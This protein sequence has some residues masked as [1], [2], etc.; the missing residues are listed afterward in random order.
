MEIIAKSN[1]EEKKEEKL[2]S[3]KIFP[4]NLIMLDI[5][6]KIKTQHEYVAIKLALR[7]PSWIYCI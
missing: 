3:N 7:N 5:E 4:Y 2:Q 6:G 1:K